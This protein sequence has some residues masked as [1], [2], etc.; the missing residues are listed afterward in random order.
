MPELPEVETVRRT[1][2]ELVKGKQ[3]QEICTTWP[4]I[5]KKPDD[6]EAFCTLLTGQSIH[7][8]GRHG[9]FLTFYLD[10]YTLVSHLRMEGKYEVVHGAPPDKHTHVRFFFTDGAEL[11]YKDVRKFG[12]MHLFNKG[13]ELQTL[14]LKQLG[15]EPV[16]D[17]LFTSDYLYKMFQ[18]TSRNVK[19]VL[20]D[21]RVVAGL[22]NIYVDE[23]L[24]QAGVRPDVKASVLSK[25]KTELLC[26]KITQTIERAIEKGGSSVRSYVNVAGEEG[27]FQL[28]LYVYGRKGETCRI[29]GDEILK[30]M[31]AGRGTHYCPSCQ[32]LL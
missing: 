6:A 18:K 16:G 21:Q 24:F 7:S 22:G 23:A 13:D 2:E 29:C 15:P 28:Q 10:D 3:L 31:T 12:T 30:M 17:V 25:D 11:R 8:I 14:P 27:G 4:K 19:A 5:I 32:P 26:E 20:L 1:L 9:K